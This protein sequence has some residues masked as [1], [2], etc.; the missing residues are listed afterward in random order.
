[1]KN[2]LWRRS[3]RKEK[4][5]RFVVEKSE[6]GEGEGVCLNARVH[7]DTDT[8]TDTDTQTQTHVGGCG[9]M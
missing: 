8:D 2:P 9:Y 3:G 7:T 5:K 6:M 4:K 1:M